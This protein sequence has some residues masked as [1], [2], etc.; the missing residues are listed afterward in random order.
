MFPMGQA[1]RFGQVFVIQLERGRQR[2][3][4]H[5][6]LVAQDFNFATGDIRI[7][8]AC[9]TVAHFSGDAQYKLAAHRFRDLEHPGTVRIADDLRQTFTVAQVDENHTAVIAAAMRPAAQADGLIQLIGVKQSA[10][11]SSHVLF[12]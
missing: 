9:R 12:L 5:L 7:G 10:V 2:G 4:Q 8:R 3:I 11:M 1:H 6:D